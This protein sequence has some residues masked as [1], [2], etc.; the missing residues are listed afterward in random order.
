M[1]SE[2]RANVE[3]RIA[4]ERINARNEGV[5]EGRRQM[6]EEITGITKTCKVHGSCDAEGSGYLSALRDLS[7]EISKLE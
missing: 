7:K 5:A 4:M 3:A 2:E 6:K 1:T